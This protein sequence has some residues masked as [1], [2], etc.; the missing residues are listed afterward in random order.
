MVAFSY[1]RLSDRTKFRILTLRHGNLDD[2]LSGTLSEQTNESYEAISWTWGTDE[3]T[4]F[5]ELDAHKRMF[6]KPN[7][8]RALKHLRRQ[9]EKRVLW[10]DAIC[11]D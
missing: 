6:I 4:S 2:Q 1:S 7:L 9:H 11:I 3:E 5:I 8:E 10:I